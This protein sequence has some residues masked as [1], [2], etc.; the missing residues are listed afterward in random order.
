MIDFKGR[1]IRK[2]SKKTWENEKLV[3]TVTSEYHEYTDSYFIV[4]EFKTYKIDV[5]VKGKGIYKNVSFGKIETLEKTTPDNNL[6]VK[7]FIESAKNHNK[8]AYFFCN[9]VEKNSFVACDMEVYDAQQ[10]LYEETMHEIGCKTISEEIEEDLTKK[11]QEII[12]QVENGEIKV[13]TKE[14]A[15]KIREIEKIQNEGGE[16]YHQPL[17]DKE[18]YEEIKNKTYRYRK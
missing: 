13:V 8:P 7:K 6:R 5:E 18:Y 16:G 15:K 3:I 12:K 4:N 10:K 2:S 17:I 9:N 11:N 1:D 14:E